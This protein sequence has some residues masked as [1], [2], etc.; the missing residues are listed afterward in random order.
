VEK[1]H[2]I[3][4]LVAFIVL[5]LAVGLYNTTLIQENY[6]QWNYGGLIPPP[7]IFVVLGMLQ[8]AVITCLIFL[9]VALGF[10]LGSLRKKS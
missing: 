8:G 1:K 10:T 2:Q 7:E 3:L 4:V 6:H 9:G 5:N